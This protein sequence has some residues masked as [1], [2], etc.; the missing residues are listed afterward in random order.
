MSTAATALKAALKRLLSILGIEIRRTGRHDWTDTSKFIPLEPTLTA[1]RESNLSIGDYIDA[2]MNKIPGA[3]Q[4]TFDGMKALGAFAGKI[5]AVVEIGPGSGRYLEKV[6]EE[7]QP[8]RCEIYET[9][10]PWALYLERTLGA[11]RQPTDGA[12]LKPTAD[13][14]V[15]LVM[16]HK[17]FN[18]IQLVSTLGYWGEMA[19]VTR[20]GGIVV[21]DLITEDCLTPE[22]IERWVRTNAR[23]GAYPAAMPSA[24]CIGYFERRGFALQGRFF[25]P[26]G[27]GR[28]ETFVFRRQRRSSELS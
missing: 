23:S 8:V 12:T 13:N 14:S 20:P 17:V 4:I 28:T 5:E 24:A 3:T 10:E 27:P 22:L 25:A 9:A 16:A 7:C 15:D 11:I 6:L 18:S 26:I 2:V 1:A 19:R 21:F